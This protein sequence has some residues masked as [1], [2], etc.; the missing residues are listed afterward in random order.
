MRHQVMLVV[1]PFRGVDRRARLFPHRQT[2]GGGDIASGCCARRIRDAT[3]IMLSESHAW[4]AR[5]FG[6]Q[7]DFF[8]P[9]ARYSV[10]ADA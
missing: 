3:T 2:L 8:V 1:V 5:R 6:L 10:L 7:S 9:V 4:F